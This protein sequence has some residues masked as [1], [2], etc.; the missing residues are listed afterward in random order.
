[1]KQ[2]ETFFQSQLNIFYQ[3][4]EEI[5]E[6]HWYWFNSRHGV[7]RVQEHDLIIN[8]IQLNYV[9]SKIMIFK[10]RDNSE[11][12]PNIREQCMQAYDWIFSFD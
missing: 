6:E 10:F 1:M 7:N 2:R 4:L 5:Q 11:M 9:D 12:P 8:H 3:V